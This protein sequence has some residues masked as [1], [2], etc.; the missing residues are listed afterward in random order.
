MDAVT[1]P[2]IAVAEELDHWLRGHV[3]VSEH[4]DVAEL[5]EI[6]AM[7]TAI[8]LSGDG[9]VLGRIVNFVEPTAFADW[10]RSMTS[11]KRSSRP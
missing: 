6:R 9:Q 7:P 1:Y 3:D 11:P 4:S 2:D 10:L 5:F 8:A